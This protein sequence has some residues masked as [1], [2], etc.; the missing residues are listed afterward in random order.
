MTNPVIRL[1]F[2]YKDMFWVLVFLLLMNTMGKYS[3]AIDWVVS[4]VGNS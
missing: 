1:D 4:Y 3:H 2:S